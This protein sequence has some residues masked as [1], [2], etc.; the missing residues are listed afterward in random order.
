MAVTERINTNS[1]GADWNATHSE[2]LDIT[3][4]NY[5]LLIESIGTIESAVSCVCLHNIA[6]NN[7]LHEKSL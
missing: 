3:N 7:L 4:K 2:A 5:L 6:H 1:S